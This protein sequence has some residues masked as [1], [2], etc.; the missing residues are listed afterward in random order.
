MP[1]TTPGRFIVFEGIDGVGKTTQSKLLADNLQKE[2]FPVLLTVEP[3]GTSFGR[4]I[5][6]ILTEQP[7]LHPTTRLMLFMAARRENVALV[8]EALSAGTHVICDRFL[9]STLAYQGS[10]GVSTGLI[11]SAHAL[12]SDGLAPDCTVYLD[13]DPELAIARSVARGET[14]SVFESTP[15]LMKKI[16]TSYL[17]LAFSSK[18]GGRVFFHSADASMEAIEAAIFHDVREFLLSPNERASSHAAKGR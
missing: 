18:T 6:K 9:W 8:R 13:M 1:P 10:M 11:R 5:K 15:G 16:R 12:V 7:D 3:G 14:L 2:G 4:Y 17:E